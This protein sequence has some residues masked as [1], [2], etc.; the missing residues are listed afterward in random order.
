[1][2]FQIDI[3]A[4]VTTL[5]RTF[6]PQTQRQ[7]G[8]VCIS[9]SLNS[10]IH[11]LPVTSLDYTPGSLTPACSIL[12][13]LTTRLSYTGVCNSQV[14]NNLTIQTLHQPAHLHRSDTYLPLSLDPARLTDTGVSIQFSP[15]NRYKWVNIRLTYTGLLHT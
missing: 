8:N 4:C 7:V 10:E 13:V 6:L 15:P 11:L 12:P 5:L 9:V 14:W 2:I 3:S 1:M